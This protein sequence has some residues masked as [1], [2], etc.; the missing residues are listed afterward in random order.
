MKEG[1]M[2]L[3][4]VFGD[5][6]Q[7]VIAKLDGQGWTVALRPNS[8]AA[9]WLMLETARGKVREFKNVQAAVGVCHRNGMSCTVLP[10]GT[11]AWKQWAKGR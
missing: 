1:E 11:E 7:P 3:A 10:P 6:A 5:R 9:S 8:P 4:A 2:V